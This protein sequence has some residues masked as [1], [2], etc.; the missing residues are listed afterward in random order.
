MRKFLI[1][2]SLMVCGLLMAGCTTSAPVG[3]YLTINAS[4]DPS[5][6]TSAIYSDLSSQVGAYTSGDTTAGNLTIEV[7]DVSQGDSILVRSPAGKTM[8]VDAG[9]ADIGP[10]IVANLKAEGVTSLDMAVASHAHEDHIG[11]YQTVISQFSIGTFYDSGYP[12]TSSTYEKLL[13]TIDQKN[14][15]FVTPLAGQTINLDPAITIE[16]LSPNGKNRGEIHD[17]ILVLRL[18][19]GK[20]SILLTGDMPDTLEKKISSS[21][22]PTTVLKVGHHGSKT[23]TSTSFLTIIK[24]EVAVISVGTGNTYDHPA[25]ETL[26]RIQATGAKTFRTDRDGTVTITTDGNTYTV[27]GS[28]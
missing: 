14:I 23:S 6:N 13:T 12:S 20:T 16:V 27:A 15:K 3:E 28:T 18:V 10:T 21:L 17:N 9:D 8:L 7:L 5:I 4:V 22:K 26:K 19:Y 24:P 1:L 2:L 25:P 11:G